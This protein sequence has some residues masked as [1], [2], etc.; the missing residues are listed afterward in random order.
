MNGRNVGPK[1]EAPSRNSASAS[2]TAELP[3]SSALAVP[4]CATRCAFNRAVQSC[5]ES[6][7]PS[8]GLRLPSRACVPNQ[9]ANAQT[10]NATLSNRAR[11]PRDGAAMILRGS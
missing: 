2:I 6:P 3:I 1:I 11:A 8:L 7:I 10:T 9:I 4:G 5:T